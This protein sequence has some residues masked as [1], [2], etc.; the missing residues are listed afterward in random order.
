M[1]LALSL[2]LALFLALLP[3]AHAAT[4]AES[5][6][7]LAVQPDTDL[8][9]E[10][11]GARHTALA[12][13]TA[14]GGYL[15]HRLGGGNWSAASAGS[16][17]GALITDGVRTARTRRQAFRVIVKLD[18]TGATVAARSAYP[19]ARGD[20]VWVAGDAVITHLDRGVP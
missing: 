3:T 1:R 2:C 5:G 6:G 10:R 14:L 12:V 4:L 16:A 18:R 13:G 15:G 8:R 7:V 17:L 19:H 11:P 9:P 20:R